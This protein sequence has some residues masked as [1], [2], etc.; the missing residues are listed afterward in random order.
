MAVE[1]PARK[2]PLILRNPSPAREFSAN[3]RDRSQGGLCVLKITMF[4]M[5]F[6][7]EIIVL[8][9]APVVTRCLWGAG[10]R[11]PQRF[12]VHQ[13][14]QRL[15]GVYML[16]RSGVMPKTRCQ[17]V[18]VHRCRS[19]TISLTESLSCTLEGC[20]NGLR[21]PTHRNDDQLPL[22][23]CAWHLHQ[24]VCRQT[25]FCPRCDS[26]SMERLLCM[27]GRGR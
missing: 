26:L 7:A 8:V 11:S 9:L 14:P 27:N 19:H 16:R 18:G 13:H 25:A 6:I 21:C 5:Q 15:A 3:C 23:F 24:V 17:K 4:M 12:C 2:S 20:K 10:G 1:T 22:R